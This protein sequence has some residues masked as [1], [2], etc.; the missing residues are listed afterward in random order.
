VYSAAYG[1]VVGCSTTGDAAG[2]QCVCVGTKQTC[3]VRMDVIF[4]T[5]TTLS[6]C[7]PQDS[8]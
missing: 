3:N 4:G 6:E 8:V 2:T 7:E 5:V 1:R